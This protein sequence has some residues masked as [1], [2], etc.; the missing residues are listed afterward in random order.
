MGTQHA[1]RV[2]IEK[3][4][5]TEDKCIHATIQRKNTEYRKLG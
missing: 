4:T 5:S 1:H 3:N 2:V